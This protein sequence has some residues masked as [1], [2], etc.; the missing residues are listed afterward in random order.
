[1]N[2]C[3]N[4][5]YKNFFPTHVYIY[6][7]QNRFLK[8]SV[9][10]FMAELIIALIFVVM[11]FLWVAFVVMIF[12]QYIFSSIAIFRMMKNQNIDYPFLAWIPI[13]RCYALGSVHDDI[14]REEGKDPYFRFILLACILAQTIFVA[15]LIALILPAFIHI[16][17]SSTSN[18]MYS[19]LSQLSSSPQSQFLGWLWLP[20]QIA[21][22]AYT[23]IYLV[24][25]N[26][27]FKKYAPE[28]QSYFV[29]SVIFTI[30]PIVPFISGL[31]LLKA[32]KNNPAEGQLIYTQR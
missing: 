14:K 7:P 30:I 12:L 19:Y 26:V 15:Y 6:I 11:L 27:I 16:G 1:M 5:I 10:L 13:V 4:L 18:Y 23:V 24:C 2:F 32:S 22:M 25:L 28:K 8:R 3:F 29:C 9:V 31:F 20:T 21:S 17:Q